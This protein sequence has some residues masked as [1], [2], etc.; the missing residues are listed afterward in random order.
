MSPYAWSILHADRSTIAEKRVEFL[1]ALMPAGREIRSDRTRRSEMLICC[2]SAAAAAAIFTADLIIPADIR[3]HG[4]YVFPLAIVGRYC[5]HLLWPAV[6][7]IVTTVLQYTAFSMQVVAAP[8][9]ISDVLVPFATSVLTLFLARSWRTSYLI[10]LNQAATDSLTE[11][12]NRRAFI[13]EVDTEIAR[14]KRYGGSFSLAVLDLDGF[15][16]LNDSKGH[17][18][19]DEALKLVADTLRRHTRNSDSLGRIGGDEFAILMPN[20][21]ADCAPTLRNLCAAIAASTA[22]ADCA[23][24]ASIG[25]KTFRSPP[26]NAI[27]ALQEADK[28]MYEAKSGGKNRAALGA[29]DS[30]AA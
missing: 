12:A 23:L 29:L 7:L 16:A 22:T 9:A 1:N 18:A 30:R 10:A 15:K 17:R 2:A 13:V 6:L 14:Q 5:G 4:L 3:L 20:T 24:T 27:F 25:C 19:G 8:S 11:L 28:V 21:A 26:E